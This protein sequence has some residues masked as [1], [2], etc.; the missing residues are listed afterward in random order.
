MP[1]RS[2]LSPTV[3]NNRTAERSTSAFDLNRSTNITQIIM[4]E[5]LGQE[6][7]PLF[8]SQA[9]R[10]VLGKTEPI[11]LRDRIVLG[12]IDRYKKY[13]HFPW[14]LLIHILLVALTSIQVVLI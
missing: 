2:P 5:D 14:K 7:Q 1:D 4:E 3:S 6:E 11:S 13:N 8:K 10:R 9:V 12:P